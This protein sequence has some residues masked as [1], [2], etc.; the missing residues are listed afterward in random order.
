M[1]RSIEA[2]F[3]AALKVLDS[4]ALDMT[5]I[6]VERG[7]SALMPAVQK[8]FGDLMQ[9]FIDDVIAFNRTSCALSNF[10]DEHRLSKDYHQA[11]LRDVAAA[12]QEFSL[13]ANRLLLAKAD[14]VRP[15][16][17]KVTPISRSK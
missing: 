9:T 4:L 1:L 15:A 10:P 16:R 5:G 2:V 8:P 14:A 13:A 17:A 6:A 12:W 11:I 7:R 3:A